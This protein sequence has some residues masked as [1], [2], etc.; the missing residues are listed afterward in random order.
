[1]GTL[2]HFGLLAHPSRSGLNSRTIN[3]D[4]WRLR[5]LQLFICNRGRTLKK[6]MCRFRSFFLF[7][8][9]S[10]WLVS[11]HNIAFEITSSWWF[12]GT[13]SFGA[14]KLHVQVILNF[15]KIIYFFSDYGPLLLGVCDEFHCSNWFYWRF[16]WSLWFKSQWL[17]RL[18]HQIILLF[19]LQLFR[20]PVIKNLIKRLSVNLLKSIVASWSEFVTLGRLLIRRNRHWVLFSWK[21][22]YFCIFVVGVVES[23]LLLLSVHAWSGAIK[24][25]ERRLHNR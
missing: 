16:N 23:M 15:F 2:S 5:C 1:M 18:I 19:T 7:R 4:L 10:L 21:S 3:L 17:P 24:S 11:F 6:L 8:W 22:I 20:K 13:R 12:E 14:L 9:S 25:L